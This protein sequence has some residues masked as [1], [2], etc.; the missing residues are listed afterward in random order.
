MCDASRMAQI[1]TVGEAARAAIVSDDTIRRA[2]D[3]G[4]LAGVR[5]AGGLRLIERAALE[6][7]ACERAEHR[8]A[9]RP[10]PRGG[11]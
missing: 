11:G 8:A 9:K 5:T 4:E 3:A 1:M 6:A 10:H 2:F 7:F